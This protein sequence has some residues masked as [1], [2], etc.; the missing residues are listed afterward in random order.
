MKRAV[1]AS[2]R[3]IVSPVFS[4]EMINA[5]KELQLVSMVGAFTPIECL[6][7]ASAGADFVKLFPASLWDLS[8]VRNVMQALPMLRLIPTG[9]VRLSDAAEWMAAGAVAVGLGGTLR[10]QTSVQEFRDAVADIALPS[11]GV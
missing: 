3:F 11:D 4:T 1:E 5:S 6:A 7:A 10:S 8:G 9:G 2:A